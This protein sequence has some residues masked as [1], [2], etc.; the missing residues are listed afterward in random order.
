[1]A[2]R[3]LL[4]VSTTSYRADD[5]AVAAERLGVEAVLGTDRCHQLAELWDRSK[6]GGSLQVEFRDSAEAAARIVFEAQTRR[7]DAI[8]PTDEPTAEI[9]ALAAS[10]LGLP[11]NSPAAARTARNKRLTREAL[12]R[13]GV[14]SPPHQVFSE[15]QAPEA[16]AARVRFPC[17]LKPLLCAASRGVMRADDRAGFVIA[18]RRLHALLQTPALR[19]VEDPDGHRILVE[20]FV[21]GAEVAVE[22]ILSKGRLEVLAREESPFF[23]GGFIEMVIPNVTMAPKIAE[24][25]R[26]GGGVS[27]SEYPPETWEPSEVTRLAADL[28]GSYDPYPSS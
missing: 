2:K 18:W 8:V 4:L 9:A 26:N 25:F 6:F 24:S 28:G 27:Q 20:D 11:G 14:P 17:V 16:V 10:L 19:A 13:E 21:P 22:G 12:A 5:F 23:M 3:V 15:D 1:M 7:Y